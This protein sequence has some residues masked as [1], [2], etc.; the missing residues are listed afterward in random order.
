MIR[1][2]GEKKTNSFNLFLRH[3]ELSVDNP[4]SR[5]L[6]DEELCDNPSTG[7]ITYNFQPY[8]FSP[9]L[10]ET[11]LLAT[12]GDLEKYHWRRVTALMRH[13]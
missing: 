5:G 7:Y 6:R 2:R 8:Y 12:R 11:H 10:L 3:L 9:A 13:V 1:Y 4:E